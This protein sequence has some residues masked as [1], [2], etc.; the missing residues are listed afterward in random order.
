[1]VCRHSTAVLVLATGMVLTPILNGAARPA[2]QQETARAPNADGSAFFPIRTF[3][4]SYN[5]AVE[6]GSAPQVDMVVFN[7]WQLDEL[8]AF[9]AENSNGKALQYRDAAAMEVPDRAGNSGAG[10]L[11]TEADDSWFLHEAQGRHFTFSDYPNAWAANIGNSEYQ[12]RWANDVEASLAENPEWDG[13]FADDVLVNT[14][15]HRLDRAREFRTQSAY[16]D[17]MLAWI[18][19]TS[20]KLASHN[21][22]FLA[23]S[24]MSEFYDQ[25]KELLEYGTGHFEEMAVDWSGR[26]RPEQMELN[27]L[28]AAD[29]LESRGQDV[30]YYTYQGDLHTNM[31]LMALALMA[32]NGHTYIAYHSQAEPL[33]KLARKL[34]TPN[35]HRSLV[36]SGP[37]WKRFFSNGVAVVNPSATETQTIGLGGT[38]Y[39]LEDH[40]TSAVTLNPHEG[41]VASSSA[42]KLKEA[43]KTPSSK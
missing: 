36:N 39:D 2:N 38:Y 29:D 1:M 18:Q 23:N 3:L 28:K 31:Y 33:Y 12:N 30:V 19:N 43:E 25:A 5:H 6:P 37:C 34:G 8:R 16:D 14:R 20:A 35:G 41:F 21:A 17:A 15:I 10:V 26:F 7:H 40:K 4:V 27:M 11:T 22:I 24:Q 9:K 32:T 42:T 13:V